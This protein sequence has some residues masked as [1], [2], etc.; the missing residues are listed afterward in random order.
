M[1][2]I[3]L[4]LLLTTSLFGQMESFN[5]TNGAPAQSF[6]SLV[7]TWHIDK[8]AT[9][10]VYAVDGRRWK[11]G[12]MAEGIA[13]K[14][15]VLYGD[16]YAEFLDNLEAYKYFPL[17]VYKNVKNFKSGII[18]V[19]FKGIS[20]RIDQAAGIAFDLK[21]NGNYLV[22]RANPLE[23]NVVLFR[24]YKGRRTSVQWIR[25]IPISPK[26]WYSLKV[27][28]KGRLIKAYLNGK[29]YI[30]YLN[31]TKINGKIGLWSKSDSYVFFDNWKID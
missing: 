23:N 28:I 8:D 16:R 12:V 9:N 31:K 18:E 6:S 20:G 30:N 13:T 5:E 29:L 10:F 1:K 27:V 15:K 26:K 3:S 24:M 2:R 7:G 11:R 22:V 21:Q 14:A 4:F 25:N 17:S 19:K